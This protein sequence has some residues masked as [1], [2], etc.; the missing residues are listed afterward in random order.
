M[1]RLIKRSLKDKVEV[2]SSNLT[3]KEQHLVN[4]MHEG[5]H[6]A[7][8]EEHKVFKEKMKRNVENADG[9]KFDFYQ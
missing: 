5:L 2:F 9:I 1:D 6:V 3:Q 7:K 8:G 4:E